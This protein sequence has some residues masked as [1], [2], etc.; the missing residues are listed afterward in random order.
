M[1]EEFKRAYGILKER[2]AFPS[3]INIQH[4]KR[5]VDYL[6]GEN[7]YYGGGYD[8]ESLKVDPAVIIV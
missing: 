6:E 4:F 2:D 7:I 1:K 3:L 8:E 5:V